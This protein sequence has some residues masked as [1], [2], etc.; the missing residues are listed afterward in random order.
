[1]TTFPASGPISARTSSTSVHGTDNIS[2]SPKRAASAGDP[3]V[4]PIVAANRLSLSRSREKL[5]ITSWPAWANKRAAFPPM[6]PAPTI[7]T[8]IAYLPSAGAASTLPGS[9]LDSKARAQSQLG[10]HAGLYPAFER[11]DPVGRPSAVARHGS[12]LNS[13]EDGLCVGADVLVGPEIEPELHRLAIA[14]DL[15]SNE[16][17]RT[18]AQA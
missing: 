7:P 8:L 4:A 1:M 11:L 5:T 10:G 15:W 12:S 9:L 6:R 2:T 18:N 16:D 14:L 17:V 13:L 3:T